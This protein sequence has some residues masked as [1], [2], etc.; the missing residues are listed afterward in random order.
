MIKILFSSA[1]RRVELMDC[2]RRAAKEYGTNIEIYAADIAPEW[3]PACHLADHA[4]EIS[5]CTEDGFYEQMLHICRE[6]AIDMIV[7]TIDTELMGYALL[8]E[9]F[10]CAGVS[11]IVPNSDF[12]AVARDKFKTT[13]CFCRG[14]ID[15]PQTWSQEQQEHFVYPV[16]AKPINGSC[17]IGIRYLRNSQD[18]QQLNTQKFHYIFQEICS[19]DEYTVNCYY[20]N[21]SLCCAVPHRRIKVR[22]GEVLFGQTVKISAFDDIAEKLAL[23][24]KDLEGVICFQAFYDNHTAKTRVI[25]VNARFGGGYPLCDH[26]GGKF[27]LWLIQKHLDGQS[28]G[29]N[30]WTSGLRMLRY[31]SACYDH[32]DGKR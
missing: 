8:K 25:E 23:L 10:R 5:R 14:G 9:K 6:H 19:G 2:F 26:A 32:V 1:G 3:S 27:A 20:E 30:H 24:F 21:G 22:D 16:I 11:V 7:P 18:L 31:D 29:S 4:L 17:S 12:V 28:Q 13:E 15:V